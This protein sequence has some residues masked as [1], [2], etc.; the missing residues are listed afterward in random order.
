MQDTVS[1]IVEQ[2]RYCMTG[3]VS[4]VAHSWG[5]IPVTGAAVELGRDR[6]REV[7]Y[8]GAVVPEAGRSMAAE[9]E[10]LALVIDQALR[11]GP[12][13]PVDFQSF[14]NAMMQDEPESVQLVVHGLM[15]TLQVTTSP[16]YRSPL[17]SLKPPFRPDTC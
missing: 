2:V 13:V 7:I 17:A 8:Y 9:N 3:S 12:T 4:L 5:G 10:A 1:V 6:V 16:M 11:T 14:A 15:L